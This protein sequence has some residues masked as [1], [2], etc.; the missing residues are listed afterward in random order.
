MTP[1]EE[2]KNNKHPRIL[3]AETV[4]YASRRPE[5]TTVGA[6]GEA[7]DENHLPRP[8]TTSQSSCFVDLEKDPSRAAEAHTMEHV[9]CG[10]PR[11]PPGRRTARI[12]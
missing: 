4:A 6:V 7:G 11:A 12:S 8:G 9:A 3:C 10:G 2:K 5:P 1:R